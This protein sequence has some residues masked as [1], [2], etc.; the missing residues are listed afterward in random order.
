MSALLRAGRAAPT[1]LAEQAAQ[2]LLPEERALFTGLCAAASC[3]F[4]A[5]LCDGDRLTE[6]DRARQEA[7]IM[8]YVADY[9]N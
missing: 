9:T 3:I 4:H 7:M 8:G 1:R 2:D 6:Q 5:A